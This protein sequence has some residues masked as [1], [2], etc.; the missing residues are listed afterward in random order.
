MQASSKFQGSCTTFWDHTILKWGN[1]QHTVPHDSSIVATFSMA[2]GYS[3]F[4][5]F[6]TMAGLEG[7][8]APHKCYS[9]QVDSDPAIKLVAQEQ[10]QLKKPPEEQVDFGFERAKQVTQFSQELQ[11]DPPSKVQAE[12]LHYHQCFGYVSPKCIQAMA[13]QGILQPT[14]QCVLSQSAL[15]AFMAK[16]PRNCGA[17]NLWLKSNLLRSS[18]L[19]LVP[20][21]Q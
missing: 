14:W 18:S 20:L 17:P 10:G 5:S 12:F 7:A 11:E 3:H 4:Q 15:H 8:D 9:I 16:P 21:C 19:C 2:P 13:C 1:F 6:C